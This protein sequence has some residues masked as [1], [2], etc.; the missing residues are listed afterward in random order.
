[1]LKSMLGK[2]LRTSPSAVPGRGFPPCHQACAIALALFL[3]CASGCTKD[4]HE[5]PSPDQ[6]QEAQELFKPGAK[7]GAAAQAADAWSIVIVSLNDAETAQQALARVHAAGV[8]DAMVE[9]RGK[10][11]VVTY[12]RYDTPTSSA[13][14]ADLK[15]IRETEY[16]RSLPFL[17]AMLAPPAR[18]IEGG[19]PEY[20]LSAAR[21][22]HPKARYSLQVGVYTRS[23]KKAPSAQ[24]LAEFR[25][26]AE[27]AVQALRREG[28]EA[29]YYHANSSS[30]VTVGAYD[31]AEYDA[32]NPGITDSPALKAMRERHPYNLVNG[33]GFRERRAGEKDWRLQPSFVVM[34]PDR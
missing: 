22:L 12:G 24:D 2:H 7:S 6:K 16:Q 14:Q 34:I 31:D 30:M 18:V 21:T 19:I 32:N 15:R 33:Q 20:N 23:D 9:Q 17:G 26:A 11:F 5:A 4:R 13:A 29:Y 10:T 8:R 1:M 28:E 27:Q 3:P 25:K